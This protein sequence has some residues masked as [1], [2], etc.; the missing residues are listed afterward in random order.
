MA[1]ATMTTEV[2]WTTSTSR[3]PGD[4]GHLDLDLA[5][6]PADSAFRRGA[7]NGRLHRPAGSHRLGLRP[8]LRL[9]LSLVPEQS[10]H[11][12]DATFLFNNWQGRRDSNPQHPVLETGA[13]PL[14]LLPCDPLLGLF[15]SG[16]LV[17]PFAVLLHLDPLWI[18]TLVLHGRIV[19]ALALLA[20]K[21]HS[22][23]HYFTTS[24]L[25][26]LPHATT[27]QN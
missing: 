4:L 14:E 24:Y 16:V 5:Q 13:L 8:D 21:C 11:S 25:E 27:T 22:N 15:V 3:W 19:S 20:S 17:T 9:G 7:C 18:V 6:I 2:D 12:L 23:P 1:T 10:R 26:A